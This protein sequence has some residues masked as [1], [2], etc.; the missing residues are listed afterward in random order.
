MS[1]GL[2]QQLLKLLAFFIQPSRKFDVGG[3]IEFSPIEIDE[4]WFILNRPHNGQMILRKLGERFK[5]QIEPFVHHSPTGEPHEPCPATFKILAFR[6]R[7]K[8][9][10]GDGES[11]DRLLHVAIGSDREFVAT[12]RNVVSKFRPE[13][14]SFKTVRWNRNPFS[15]L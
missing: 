13:V 11:I 15:L 14:R 10:D 12:G 8:G 2:I 3:M 4:L 9:F 1:D 5:H 6:P 7:P